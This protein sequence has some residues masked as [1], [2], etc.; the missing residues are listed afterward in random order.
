MGS[1]TVI[2]DTSNTIVEI[3]RKTMTPE[4]IEK[5]ESIGLCQP[6]DRN[7]FLLGVYLYQIQENMEMFSQEKITLDEIHYKNPPMSFYLDYMIFV[8]SESEINTRLIDEQRIIGRAIQQMNNHRKVPERFLMGTL[9]ENQER[10]YIQAMTLS[11][12]ERSKIWSL[13]HQPYRTCFFYRAGPVFLD[14]DFIKD[15]KRV[16]SAE[17]SIQQ[18]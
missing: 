12:E 4:P 7:G 3:L 1:Y 14:T 5:P 15:V 6:D 11:L 17:I 18:K 2:A 10:I 8:H 9:K 16:V 13:F